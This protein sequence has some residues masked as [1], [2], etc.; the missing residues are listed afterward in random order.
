MNNIILHIP[1][2]STNIPLFDGYLKPNERLIEEMNLLTDWFTDELYD[3]PYKKIVT[4]FSRIFCDVER[5]SDDSLEVMSQYGM[6]MCYTHMD[7]G[8]LMRTV[9]PELRQKIKLEYYDQHHNALEIA[10]SEALKSNKK[11]LVIDC[12][13]FP[14]KPLR[15]D[16]SQSNPKPDFCIG[17]DDFHTPRKLVSSSFAFLNSKGYNVFE[18]DPF[19]GTMIPMKYFRRDKNVLGIMIEVNRKLYMSDSNEKVEKTS[20][21]A[22][23][24]QIIAEL[25]LLLSSIEI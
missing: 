9:S 5:F 12:H 10:C 6:G 7:N 25:I 23:I 18:N 1:H 17:S 13:S 22:E 14:D 2:S 24:R 4:P 21:F 3:L 15:R 20:N 16:L 8:E 11:V 19:S